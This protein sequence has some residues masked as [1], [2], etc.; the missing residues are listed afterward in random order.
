M[1]DR[2]WG[3]ANPMHQCKKPA[4]FRLA[5][6]GGNSAVY[7]NEAYFRHKMSKGQEEL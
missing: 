5:G 3:T 6:F 1:E 7:Q 2:N 4:G